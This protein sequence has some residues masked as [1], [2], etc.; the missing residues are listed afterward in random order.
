[1]ERKDQIVH[2][3]RLRIALRRRLRIALRERLRIAL[4]ERQAF[5]KDFSTLG[6]C[7]CFGV[8]SGHPA[9]ISKLNLNP[10]FASQDS[11]HHGSSLATTQRAEVKFN[12]GKL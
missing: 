1:M 5:L 7:L 12:I 11:S 3:V 9:A 4:R 10:L 6:S 2:D 8:D